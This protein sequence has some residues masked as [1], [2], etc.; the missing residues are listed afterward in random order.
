MIAIVDAAAERGIVIGPAT[1]TG[2]IGG[3]DQFDMNTATRQRHRGAK[4]RKT[5]AHDINSFWLHAVSPRRSRI[6]ISSTLLT[7][8][9]A[10]G[11]AQPVRSI[12]SRI[13]S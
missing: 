1:A 6:P 3:L 11:G 8:V 4:S 7:R 9:R 2:L 13:R 5:G 12:L 10:R